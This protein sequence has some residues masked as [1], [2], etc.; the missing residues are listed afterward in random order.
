M[1]ARLNARTALSLLAS[2]ALGKLRSD[3]AIQWMETK[4]LQEKSWV[5]RAEVVW[6]LGGIGRSSSL[7]GL[8]NAL[9][10]KDP[11]V[12]SMA[13]DSLGLMKD[14]E[15]V[16]AI[17][18]LLNDKFWQVRVAAVGALADIDSPKAIGPLVERMAK[19]DG[20]LVAEIDE[21]LESLTN[22]KYYKSAALWKA[23]YERNKAAIEAGTW[24]RPE[25][26]ALGDAD[27]GRVTGA[28]FFGIPLESK[29]VLFILDNSGSMKA[30]FPRPERTGAPSPEVTAGPGAKKADPC[31]IRVPGADRLSAAKEE[32]LRALC[33]L[34]EDANFNVIVFSTA[35]ER[36][37]PVMLKATKTNKEM[38]KG[39]ILKLPLSGSTNTFD[40]LDAA[41]DLTGTGEFDRNYKVEI[42]T[43][44][45]LS[46]GTPTCGRYVDPERIVREVL[47]WNR[48]RKIKV[49]TIQIGNDFAGLGNLGGMF[50]GGTGGGGG[51]GNAGGG[52]GG[53]QSLQ[54]ML[55]KMLGG[56]GGGNASGGNA[57]GGKNSGGGGGGGNQRRRRGGGRS[58]GFMESLAN[59]TGGKFTSK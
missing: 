28:A 24:T 30:D 33:Q 12:R 47:H 34:P 50:P 39:E 21:A 29:N 11:V 56:G 37:S 26:P 43:I 45:F 48:Y 22:A 19:E 15:A 54:D 25:K 27:A 59:G 35:V 52:G 2:E 44:Y 14:T 51:G 10:D 40:S 3:D 16:A 1:A 57:G 5:A 9:K 46:D 20:R 31:D 55:K 23:W 17:V 7:P 42:D 53:G 41:F 18:A 4:G 6:A 38:M 36:M 49:H 58:G 8:R 13:C 32:L